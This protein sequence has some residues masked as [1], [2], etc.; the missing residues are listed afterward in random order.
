MQ[1]LLDSMNASELLLLAQET[2]LNAHRG[3][4]RETLIQLA[5]G[6]EMDLPDRRIDK[7]RLR[8]MQ[9]IDANFRQVFPLVQGCPA[10]TRDLRA[11]FQCTD[12]QAVECALTNSFILKPDN[13]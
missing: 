9:W 2:N 5:Q 6:S 10:K 8:V 3:L 11:C 13:S 1:D 4:P 7:T 12:V